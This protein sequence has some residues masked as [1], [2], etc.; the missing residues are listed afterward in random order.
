M[1]PVDGVGVSV[2]EPILLDATVDEDPR[3]HP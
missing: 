1:K 2:A 3:D